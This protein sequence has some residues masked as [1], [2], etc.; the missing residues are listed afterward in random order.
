MQK[1]ET[2][3]V[4]T[5]ARPLASIL[6]LH[7]L[8]AD[9]HDFEPIVRELDLRDQLAIRFVFP[10]AP[11]RPVTINNGMV[12]RAWYDIV[13]FDRDGLQDEASI[14]A[15]AAALRSLIEREHE[16]G[17]AYERI[18]VAGFS[19]GGAIALHEGLRFPHRLAGIMALSTYL[20]LAATLQAEVLE[21]RRTEP[22]ALPVFMAHGLYDPVLPF[23]F[24]R[25]SRD[26]L[27]SAGFNVEW[28]EYPMPHAVCPDEIAAIRR[29][30]LA[31][32]KE[33]GKAVA[34][35]KGTGST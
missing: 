16:R 7:G 4:E 14:R 32:L 33:A 9:G 12:M 25:L 34:I 5:G 15:S 21:G 1:L 26:A 23:D 24:G 35:E 2:V 3:E 20:P 31:V 17:I 18:V 19:Q 13:S 29:W 30:L 8:G 27:E 11:L 22:A 10:H 28:H 6:W